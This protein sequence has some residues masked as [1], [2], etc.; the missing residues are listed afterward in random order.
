[1]VNLFFNGIRKLSLV[2]PELLLGK[3]FDEIGFNSIKDELFRHLVLTRL[4]YPVS[5]LKTTDYLFK[6]KGVSIDVESVYRYMDKLNKKQKEQIQKISYDH[7][8]KVLNNKM[9]IV[10]YDVTTLYFET[11][12]E[13]EL[14]RTGFSKDGKHQ[15]PQIFLGL[16]VSTGGYPLAYEMFEGKKFEGHTMLPVI[17]AFKA[18]YELKKMVV[19]AD[20]GLMSNDNIAELQSKNYEYIL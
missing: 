13:D 16:L 9:S 20:A 2:G 5:K 15:Q 7:T 17:E 11:E 12:Q 10:F 19:I 18:K 1:M 6:Y 4:C 8:L 3:L 14:R